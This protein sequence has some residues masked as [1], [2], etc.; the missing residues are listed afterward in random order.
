[1]AKVGKQ[2]SGAKVGDGKTKTHVY[3]SH[4]DSQANRMGGTSVQIT[5]S[6]KGVTPGGRPYSYEKV[7]KG[8]QMSNGKFLD[9]SKQERG[10]YGGVTI[11]PT[12]HSTTKIA[13]GGPKGKGQ[14]KR[15][16]QIHKTDH[17]GK[18]K[19]VLSVKKSDGGVLRTTKPLKKGPTRPLK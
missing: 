9:N 5:K 15:Y 3:E 13:L 18:A 12:T 11:K 1:M 4:K 17:G 2:W 16:A 10:A 6:R 7:T 8:I 19:Q 14:A